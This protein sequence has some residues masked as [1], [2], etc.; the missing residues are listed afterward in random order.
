VK[1]GFGPLQIV[2]RNIAGAAR[3]DRH[4]NL[5]DPIWMGRTSRHVDDGK[6]RLRTISRAQ[7]TAIGA[8]QELPARLLSDGL[9][10][11]GRNSAPGGAIAD[12]HHIMGDAGE[13]ADPILHRPAGKTIPLAG[14]IGRPDPRCLQR[15]EWSSGLSPEI[16]PRNSLRKFFPKLPFRERDAREYD[17]EI[18]DQ[19]AD[20]G[21]FRIQERMV[22]AGTRAT[23]KPKK[24]R[25]CGLLR[26]ARKD[27]DSRFVDNPMSTIE[28]RGKRADFCRGRFSWRPSIAVR[29]D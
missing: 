22:F 19:I 7:K 20:A 26:H 15:P 9:G 29:V 6:P 11:V 4:Q 5:A 3:R 8:L 23:L 21:F 18:G 1:K 25:I 24:I 27:G 10:A 2:E 13:I 16:S 12:R 14:A 17:P 28:D